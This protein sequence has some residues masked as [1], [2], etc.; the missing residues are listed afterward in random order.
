M[1][2]DTF[3]YIGQAFGVVPCSMYGTTEVGVLIVN[4]PGLARG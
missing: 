1:D 2:P 3:A 4:F